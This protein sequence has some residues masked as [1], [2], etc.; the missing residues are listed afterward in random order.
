MGLAHRRADAAPPRDIQIAEPAVAIAVGLFG[1]VFLPQ[2]EQRHA[3]AA[4][5]GM[6]MG[7]VRH[8]PGGRLVEPGGGEQPP[9]QLGVV[10]LGRHRPGDPDHRRP[11]QVF[12][13]RRVSHP[14]RARD[15]PHAR[16]ARILQPQNFS[17]L[18]HR[19]SLGWHRVPLARRTTLPVIGSS[20]SALQ[21]P[22]RVVRDQSESPSGI[23]S[24]S[25]SA[26]RRN[27][28]PSWLG[29]WRLL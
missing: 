10:D 7:P 2:Q 19:Q 12:P 6:D 27:H 21:A 11:A 24:E 22:L 3:T 29:I 13:D 18:P 26:L 28:C 15:R 1:P 16:A 5:L 9:L 17:H 4:Q 14:D 20:T 25:V 8:G 23:R